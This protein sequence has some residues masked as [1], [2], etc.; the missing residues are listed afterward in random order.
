MPIKQEQVPIQAPGPL[1]SACLPCRLFVYQLSSVCGVSWGFRA[2]QQ[3]RGLGGRCAWLSLLCCKE[4]HSCPTLLKFGS[5]KANACV[6]SL[7]CRTAS[8]GSAQPGS[9][10]CSGAAS[11]L[12]SE[13]RAPHAL[14]AG[15]W[16]C[17]IQEA[18]APSTSSSASR[19]LSMPAPVGARGIKSKVTV[20]YHPMPEPASDTYVTEPQNYVQVRFARAQGASTQGGFKT[21]R[22]LLQILCGLL[23]AVSRAAAGTA[24]H[25]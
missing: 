11:W 13:Q 16:Q 25:N 15:Q 1:L 24:P 2:Q 17:S 4:M 8:E 18:L 12:L 22:E 6:T 9:E 10:G 7:I 21:Q 23:P 19:V 14:L 3:V 20:E 5:H